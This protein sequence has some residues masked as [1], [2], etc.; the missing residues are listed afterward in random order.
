MFLLVKEFHLTMAILSAMK[1]SVGHRKSNF[2]FFS[3][4]DETNTCMKFEQNPLK[5]KKFIACQRTGHTYR[6][7]DRATVGVVQI[8]TPYNYLP[9]N[10]SLLQSD[11]YFQATNSRLFQTEK[12]CRRQFQIC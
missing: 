11:M 7:T 8:N 9:R 5:I 3:D 1:E 6:Q 4:I 12:V 2:R 10:C